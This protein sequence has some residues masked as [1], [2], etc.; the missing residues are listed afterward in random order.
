MHTW[1][2]MPLLSHSMLGHYCKHASQRLYQV[3]IGD[4]SWTSLS[5][6]MTN[7]AYF[8]TSWQRIYCTSRARW[9]TFRT[10]THC[11]PLLTV[12]TLYRWISS[13]RM[14]FVC[15]TSTRTI[16]MYSSVAWQITCH[17]HLAVDTL[18]LRIIPMIVWSIALNRELRSC[19]KRNKLRRRLKCWRHWERRLKR[20]YRRR[21]NSESNR[22]HWW[23]QIERS[24]WK[25]RVRMNYVYWREWESM[26]NGEMRELNT[27]SSWK[28]LF[29]LL[30]RTKRIRE[31]LI[32]N[33]LR[34]ILKHEERL[35]NMNIIQSYRMKP[36]L[37]WSRKLLKE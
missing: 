13:W 20:C 25:R 28:E 24:H 3:K 31:L 5:L 27:W 7:L 15:S 19:L 36:S 35:L 26:T 4:A 30:S 29:T 9:A 12:R 16:M 14:L 32:L 18:C 11:T 37:T 23:W 21:S 2:I 17:C 1:N 10:L 33:D 22:K 34:L 8:T 6:T